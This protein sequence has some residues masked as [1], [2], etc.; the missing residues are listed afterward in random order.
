MFSYF[1][2]GTTRNYISVF[3]SLFNNI[4]I[5]REDGKII[6][7]PI[8]F[9]NKEK[10]IA[11]FNSD[12]FKDKTGLPENL[13][14]VPDNAD[15]ATPP[16]YSELTKVELETILPRIGYS[17]NS[18]QYDPMRKTNL[19]QNN[20][21]KKSTDQTT[22][23]VRNGVPYN[24]SF[25]LDIYARYEDDV[26]QIIE[27]I[28]PFFQPHFNVTIEDLHHEDDIVINKRDIQIDLE[29]VQPEED[30]EG[31]TERRVIQW[32]LTFLLK[33]YYYPM[34]SNNVKEIKSTI[35]NLTSIR[36]DVTDVSN[37]DSYATAETANWNVEPIAARQEDN[38]DEVSVWS[39]T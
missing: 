6:R 26:L 15:L 13:N 9:A 11:K 22:S 27:Q 29:A 37:L 14:G 28:V 33:G 23:M 12:L 8:G 3:G 2:H 36:E 30:Y 18:M 39:K 35:V 5:K 31:G 25:E 16:T 20:R 17:M 7:V 4:T 21:F 34:V 24:L 38:P 19:L 1:Y 32:S 10:Y